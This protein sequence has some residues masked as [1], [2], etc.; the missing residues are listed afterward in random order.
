MA[1]GSSADEVASGRGVLLDV[2]RASLRAGLTTH[3]PL[4]VDPL[5]FPPALR[6][7]GASFVTLR[8]EGALRGC[9]GSLE[10]LRALVADVA[11]NA[12]QAGF[13]DPRFRPLAPGEIAAVDVHV[14]V[15][16]PLE[17]LEVAGEDELLAR[18]RPG[19][20]GLVLDDGRRRGT[21]LPAVWET[22]PD[23]RDFLRE[24]RRK[25][26]LAAEGWPPELRVFR[27][28]VESLP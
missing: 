21:F 6:E 8:Q 18:L 26:G 15:L 5:R 7:A 1:P 27:Y 13:G 17:R 12:F 20:D 4:V 23:P 22:L 24:L 10:S 16:S 25:T 11:H 9:V 3:R 2:A 14:S 19:T 28:T